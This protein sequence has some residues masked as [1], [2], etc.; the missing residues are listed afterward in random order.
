MIPTTEIDD[1]SYMETIKALKEENTEFRES[2]E[3]SEKCRLELI[4]ENKELE[5]KVKVCELE[6]LKLQQKL[7]KK[8]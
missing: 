1:S 3:F 8:I 4:K 2:F 6:I 5:L 7:I